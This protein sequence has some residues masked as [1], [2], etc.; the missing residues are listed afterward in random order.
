[1]FCSLLVNQLCDL[2]N[3][4]HQTHHNQTHHHPHDEFQPI[5]LGARAGPTALAADGA[6]QTSNVGITASHSHASARLETH[7]SAGLESDEVE[8]DRPLSPAAECGGSAAPCGPT[9][10]NR[11]GPTGLVRGG[12]TGLVRDG[13]VIEGNH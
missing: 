9:G 6:V 13:S 7:D 5:G 8:T 10:F 2:R 12:P 1:M 3:S 4:L 11:G